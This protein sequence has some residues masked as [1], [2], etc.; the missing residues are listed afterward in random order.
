M[1]PPRLVSAVVILRLLKQ[2]GPYCPLSS[3]SP[4]VRPHL[5]WA[6]WAAGLSFPPRVLL[7]DR[8]RCTEHEVSTTLQASHEVLALGAF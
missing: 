7:Q 8:G 1:R 4:I 5:A 3:P 2:G 6:S